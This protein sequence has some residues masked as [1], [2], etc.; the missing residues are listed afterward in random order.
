MKNTILITALS[1]L[2]LLLTP[3]HAENS[4]ADKPA[5]TEKKATPKS[6]TKTATQTTYTVLVSGGG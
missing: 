2:G 1:G 3:L 6:S 5:A 4:T